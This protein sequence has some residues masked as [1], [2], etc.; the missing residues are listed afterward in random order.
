MYILYTH[1]R[2]AG[3]KSAKSVVRIVFNDT[4]DIAVDRAIIEV[5]IYIYI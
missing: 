2:R 1:N 3:F 5:Y 4:L